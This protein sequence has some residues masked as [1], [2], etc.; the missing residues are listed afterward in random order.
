[1]SSVNAPFGLRPVYKSGGTPASLTL[2]GTITSGYG[3]AIFEGDAVKLVG[4]VLVSAD[5]RA[6]SDTT[7]GIIGTFMGVE[8]T[9]ANG[10]R[11]ESNQWIASLSATNIVAYYTADP[12]ITYEIQANGS[13]T[14]AQVGGEVDILNTSQ[15]AG[16]TV[17]GLSVAV[18]N[19]SSGYNANGTQRTLRIV[20]LT[21][22]ADNA[23]GDAFTVIQVQ[24]AKHQWTN[25]ITGVA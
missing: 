4:G 14:Q 15:A 20:G 10:R 12:Y 7:G 16:S 13:V 19:I 25:P 1:M 22:G 3:T 9:D 18:A 8:Y 2:M 11:Q 21:P 23:F 5:G 17:T 6:A 24:I